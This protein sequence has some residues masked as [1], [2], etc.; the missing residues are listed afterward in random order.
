MIK[1]MQSP[2]TSH[3]DALTYGMQNLVKE[4][5]LSVEDLE[6]RE[7]VVQRFRDTIKPTYP[8]NRISKNS[9]LKQNI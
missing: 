8:G 7:K 3:S 9:I 2:K 6:I 5:G 4:H 1:E